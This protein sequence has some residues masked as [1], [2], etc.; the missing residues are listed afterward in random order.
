MWPSRAKKRRERK[1]HP[2][3]YPVSASAGAGALE[4][5]KQLYKRQI[6]KKSRKCKNVVPV[7]CSEA[8]RGKSD[9]VKRGI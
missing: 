6:K 8:K 1:V 4:K 9:T 2:E 7:W 3:R 5:R